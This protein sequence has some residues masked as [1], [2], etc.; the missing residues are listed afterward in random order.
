MIPSRPL[1]VYVDVDDTL[2]RSAGSKRIPIPRV[3]AHIRDLAAGGAKLY[4]WS[5]VGA[6]YAQ[7]T[8]RELGIESCFVAFLPKPNV[9]IDDQTIVEWRRFVAIHPMSIEARTVE[10]YWMLIEGQTTG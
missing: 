5:T 9:V 7:A 1:I 4:C 6:E 10:Q 3:V 8:A 2:V